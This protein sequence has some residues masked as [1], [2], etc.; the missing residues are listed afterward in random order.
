MVESLIIAPHPDDEVLGCSSFL[1]S[2]CHVLFMTKCKGARKAE[3]EECSKIFGYSSSMAGW[4]DGYLSDI[5]KIS[6]YISQLVN[7]KKP[8]RVLI[9]YPSL[10]QDHR[11]TNHASLIALREYS[12]DILEYEYPE[13]RSSF[14]MMSPNLYFP[15]T[16][17]GIKMKIEGMRA[18]YSQFR[19]GR[20]EHAINALSVIRGF[21]CNTEHAEAFR[22]VRSV[23]S[24]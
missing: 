4:E 17:E 15:M 19:D 20:D 9:P 16:G 24:L 3:S 5:P 11:V 6:N 14:E 8:K 22:L 1:N 18:Y 21:E 7:E 12:G 13:G 23:I 10:H 2:D